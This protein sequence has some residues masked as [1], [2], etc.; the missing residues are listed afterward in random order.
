MPTETFVASRW[1]RGNL[2]FPTV[3]EITDTAVTCRQRSFF[4]RNEMS[5]HLQQVA[6]VHIRTGFFWSEILIES[7]GGAD[8]ISSHGH[9]K[10]DALRVKE[11]LEDAQ[12]NALAEHP[13]EPA[14]TG[15]TRECPFCAETIKA[16]AKV[17]RYCQRDL[18]PA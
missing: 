13:G 3:L 11:R 17:C 9:R 10:A 12:R 5:F 1:T 7:S 4:T 15:P 16:A 14:S 18:P 8:P 6:S 2:W